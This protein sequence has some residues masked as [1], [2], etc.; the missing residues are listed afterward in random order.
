TFVDGTYSYNL[1]ATFAGSPVTVTLLDGSPATNLFYSTPNYFKIPNGVLGTGDFTLT[2]TPTWGSF[3]P[4][5]VTFTNTGTCST[6]CTTASTGN[7]VTYY[8]RTPEQVTDLSASALIPKFDEGTNRKLTQVKVD[9]G[10]YFSGA[11]AFESQSPLA[12][13]FRYRAYSD[14][15]F[16][17]GGFTHA[18]TYELFTNP[19]YPANESYPPAVDTPAVAAWPGVVSPSPYAFS[20]M[21]VYP[22]NIW[23]LQSLRLGLDP[24]QNPNWVTNLS[25]DSTFDDDIFIKSFNDINYNG[26]ATYSSATDIANFIGT[27]NVANSFST[28]S[29]M[30]SNGSG[31]RFISQSLRGS[32]YY[33]VEYTYDCIN[34]IDAVDDTASTPVNGVTGGDAGINV[35]NNDTLGTSAA[36]ASNVTLT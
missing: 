2:L 21:F 10:V 18:N 16:T 20:R 29:S 15:S 25:G 13:T 11:M 27:G 8:Y 28:F 23:L 9:Y 26:S 33:K 24:R 14:L 4:E 19:S 12:S 22:N 36:T 5:T 31:T 7:V 34:P 6:V 1:T 30:N 3:T 17:I 32:L 35:Y